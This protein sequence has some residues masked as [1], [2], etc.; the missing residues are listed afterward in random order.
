[1]MNMPRA[2]MV[3]LFLGSVA[4]PAGTGLAQTPD[5]TAGTNAPLQAATPADASP[6]TDQQTDYSWD[7][8]GVVRTVA[9][10]L[11]DEQGGWLH[12]MVQLAPALLI[13]TL[14]VL[15][16]TIT[17]TSLRRD[18]KQRRP[19]AYRPRGPHSPGSS[20]H[21]REP[22]DPHDPAALARR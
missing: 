4:L 22:G 3:A 10:A 5:N 7:K 2:V 1:M 20:G 13:L 9:A 19:V 15:G 11:P 16:L 8:P 21:D 17:F 14:T 6:A 12:T 18:M